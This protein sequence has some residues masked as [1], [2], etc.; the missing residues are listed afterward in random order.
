MFFLLLFPHKVL[1]RVVCF[2]RWLLLI[3]LIL[4]GR[5]VSL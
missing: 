2:K 5:F 4:N 1:L 3:V